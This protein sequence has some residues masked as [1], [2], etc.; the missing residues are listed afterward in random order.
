[1]RSRVVV[2]PRHAEKLHAREPG[3]LSLAVRSKGSRAGKGKSRTSDVNG[4][5]ESDRVVVPMK[6]FEQSSGATGRGGGEGGG[7]DANQGEHPSAPHAPGTVRTRRV[8]GLD[9]C[10]LSRCFDATHP[11]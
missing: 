7:K 4:G 11:R 3:D 8:P 1:M 5:E 2:D 10:A 6:S 9:G